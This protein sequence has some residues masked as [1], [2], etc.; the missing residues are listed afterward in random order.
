MIIYSQHSERAVNSETKCYD[1]C[2]FCKHIWK[3]LLMCRLG[4][5]QLYL[6][7]SSWARGPGKR[8][9]PISTCMK[10]IQI[11]INIFTVSQD[12]LVNRNQ[13]TV[14]VKKILYSYIKNISMHLIYYS[15]VK[16]CFIYIQ[17]PIGL[18]CLFF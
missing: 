17:V 2:S 8:M 1:F 14:F 11:I 13:V 3:V 9:P 10:N 12:S 5:F 15:F 18:L 7:E 6:I 16:F 4:I